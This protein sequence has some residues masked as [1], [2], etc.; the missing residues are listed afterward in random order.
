MHNIDRLDFLSE[1]EDNETRIIHHEDHGQQFLA[2]TLSMSTR[3]FK[4]RFR[5][6]QETFRRLSDMVILFFVY[7]FFCFQIEE[8][9]CSGPYLLEEV[10]LFVFLRYAAT[11]SFMK[12]CADLCNVSIGSAWNAIHQMIKKTTN[13]DQD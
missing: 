1:S 13:L 6:S 7:N 5:M 8:E 12:V 10:K 11:G 2:N 4:A 3:E 9:N